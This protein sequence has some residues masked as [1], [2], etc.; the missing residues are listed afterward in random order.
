M[1]S[2]AL[3]PADRRVQPAKLAAESRPLAWAIPIA[4]ILV[5]LALSYVTLP[6]GPPPGY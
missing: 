1:A 3:R 5:L 4:I 6:N 2:W